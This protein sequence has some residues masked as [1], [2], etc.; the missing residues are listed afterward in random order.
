MKELNTKLN[1][2]V[3]GFVSLI[4]F[5]MLYEV[6]AE[7]DFED[8]LDDALLAL[9]GLAAIWW[10][11]KSGHTGHSSQLAWVVSGVAV[12]LKILAIAIEHADKEALG[13][14]IGILIAFVLLFAFVL[15]QTLSKSK[16]AK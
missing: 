9:L 3:T 2:L 12:L 5:T 11:K 13:D 4:G 1:F 16:S 6:K 14:D 15:W 10:Y 7:D 8:K